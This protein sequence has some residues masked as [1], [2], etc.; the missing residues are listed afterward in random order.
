MKFTSFVT[1][2][3]NTDLAS[4]APNFDTSR[5]IITFKNGKDK[6][7]AETASFNVHNQFNK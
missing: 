1:I 2:F 5:M 3:T 4:I 7:A 6:V